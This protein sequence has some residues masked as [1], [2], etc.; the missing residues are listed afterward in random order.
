MA[1]NAVRRLSCRLRPLLIQNRFRVNRDRDLVADYDTAPVERGVP[2][3][4]EIVAVQPAG[5]HKAGSR[6]WTFIDSIFPPR[7]RPL[8]EIGGVQSQWPGDAADCHT[9]DDPVLIG[10]HR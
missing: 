6:L 10:T 5:R 4:A 7:C 9:T 3:Y 1:E 8:A 2:A